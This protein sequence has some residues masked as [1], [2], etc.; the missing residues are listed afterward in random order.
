MRY[1]GT[2]GIRSEKNDR[3][4]LRAGLEKFADYVFV[5]ILGRR[6][7]TKKESRSDQDSV[8]KMTNGM[9]SQVKRGSRRVAFITQ[10]IYKYKRFNDSPERIIFIFKFRFSHYCSGDE[11]N[12]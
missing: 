9:S 8:R 6:L 2:P 1:R 4:V 12:Q 10:H 11:D 5:R 3:P 7:K